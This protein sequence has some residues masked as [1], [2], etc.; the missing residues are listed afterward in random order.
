MAEPLPAVLD[1]LVGRTAP[2][3]R[4]GEI[5]FDAPWESRLFGLTMTLLR[6]GRFEWIEFQLGLVRE[7]AKWD[8]DPEHGSYWGCWQRAFE[9]LLEEKGLCRGAELEERAEALAAR[10]RGHDHR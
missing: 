10:P 6:T 7:V 8:A 5:V 2:P 9:A 1:E 4:N 3:R